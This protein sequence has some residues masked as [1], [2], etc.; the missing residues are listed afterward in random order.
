M[1]S[2]GRRRGE[3]V[4]ARSERK[5]THEN[6]WS[7]GGCDNGHPSKLLD[8]IHLVEEARQNAV[9]TARAL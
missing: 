9:V 5:Y 3:T 8:A 1:P 2:P 7:I 4:G 6:V